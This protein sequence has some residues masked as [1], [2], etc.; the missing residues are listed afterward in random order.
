MKSD[1]KMW[2]FQEIA[3]QAELNRHE[4]PDSAEDAFLLCSEDPDT[5][6]RNIEELRSII[7]E[8]GECQPQRMDDAYL[9]RF[10]RARQSIPARAHRLLVRYCEFKEQNPHLW[11]DIEWF[12]LT[13]LGNIYE[14]VLYDRPDVGRLIVLR[15]GQWDPDVIP[16]IDL[17]RGCL[18]LLEIGIMQPKLQILGGTALIDCEGLSLKQVRQFSP[19]IAMLIMAVLG[20]AFPLHQRGVHVINCSRLMETLFPF[21]KRLAPNDDLWKKLYIHGYDLSSLRRHIDPEC[22]PRRYGGYRDSVSLELWLTKI[23]Q[24]RDKDFDREMRNIGYAV[25]C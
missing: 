23:R 24:Y 19:S 21:F 25:K 17:I 16:V 10:L 9:L 11:R 3:F 18:L 20:H 22:L 15:M 7:K 12:S 13:R 6:Q 1:I 2:S 5:R 14:G 8:R 4:E